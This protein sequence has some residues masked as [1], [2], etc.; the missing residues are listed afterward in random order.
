[1]TETDI[2]TN[3]YYNTD[4]SLLPIIVIV[5]YTMLSQQTMCLAGTFLYTGG[6]MLVNT[7]VTYNSTD[8]TAATIWP[9]SLQV[10]TPGE[11]QRLPSDQQ[12]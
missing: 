2:E 5:K 6:Y 4:Y 7:D 12:I 1:M 9:T 3:D 10:P 8:I 11:R